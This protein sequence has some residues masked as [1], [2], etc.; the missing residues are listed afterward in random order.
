M[1]LRQEE[2][3]PY[4]YAIVSFSTTTTLVT[5]ALIWLIPKT[6]PLLLILFRVMESHG[7]LNLGVG[8]QVRPWRVKSGRGESDQAVE[9]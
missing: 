9:S 8:S 6:C 4:S 3:V 1:A 7:E 5:T 2:H